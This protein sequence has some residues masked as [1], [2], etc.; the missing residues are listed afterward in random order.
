M[1]EGIIIFIPS[2]CKSSDS[3]SFSLAGNAKGG[4]KILSV[5]FL[6]FFFRDIMRFDIETFS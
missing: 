1:F 5:Q 3:S 2:L 6:R 4:F